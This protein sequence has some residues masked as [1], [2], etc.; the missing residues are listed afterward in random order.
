VV[1][2]WGRLDA[3]PEQPAWALVQAS[4]NPSDMDSRWRRSLFNIE[5]RD[6]P[7]QLRPG[8]TSDG[9][10]HAFQRYTRPL[11]SSDICAFAS[12]RFLAPEGSS[13]TSAAAIERKTWRR[14]AGAEPICG[15]ER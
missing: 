10:W 4:R 3:A 2:L 15:L 14:V 1:L 6:P 9:T 12:V 13:R 5:W 8:Y 7:A 11:T